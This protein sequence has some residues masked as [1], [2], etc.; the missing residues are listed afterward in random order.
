MIKVFCDWCKKEALGGMGGL[1]R[2]VQLQCMNVCFTFE[3]SPDAKPEHL[4][5]PCTVAKIQEALIKFQAD[6][7]EN[8]F[9]T[10][11]GLDD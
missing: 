2:R 11:V 3:F 8:E 9:Y 1:F 6:A 7:V 10:E 5:V 4:C